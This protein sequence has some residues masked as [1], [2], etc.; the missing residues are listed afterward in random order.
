MKIGKFLTQRAHKGSR[1]TAGMRR[2]IKIGVKRSGRRGR[3][4]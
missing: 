4:R 2:R 3:R 1:G